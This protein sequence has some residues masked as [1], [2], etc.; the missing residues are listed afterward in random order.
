MH[1]ILIY[2]L[3]SYLKKGMSFSSR[4]TNDA[5]YI[6]DTIVNPVSGVKPIN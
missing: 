5:S 4:T 3:Y 2:K 1:C 6:F